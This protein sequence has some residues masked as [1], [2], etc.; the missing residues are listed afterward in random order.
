MADLDAP[1]PHEE[2]LHH[3]VRV[4]R[5]RDGEV[6]GLS[7]GQGGWRL[8]RLSVGPARQKANLEV[9]GELVRD[10]RPAPLITI[11]LALPKGERADWAVQ[12]LTELGVDAIVVLDARRSV[13]RWEGDRAE[14]GLARLSRIARQAAAQSR[15]TRLPALSGPLPVAGFPTATTAAAEP[16]S[17]LGPDLERPTVLVGPEGGWAESEVPSEMARIGLGPGVLR[18]E[19]AALAAAVLLVGLRSGLTT[20]MPR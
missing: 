14:K 15:R 2:D 10:P 9:T 7:D 19:T 12:K 3:L 16:G 11:G 20:A 8:A 5:L 18:T 4:L 1:E 17:A 6:V 13:V